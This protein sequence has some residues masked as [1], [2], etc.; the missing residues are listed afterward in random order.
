MPVQPVPVVLNIGDER[1]ELSEDNC[2]VC[3]FTE[4]PEND[5]IYVYDPSTLVIYNNRAAIDQLM[6]L[7]YPMQVRRL[8]TQWDRDAYEKYIDMLTE[9]LDH[10]LEEM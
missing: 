7:G 4:A 1:I 5:H 10:E 2:W 9:E 8:P 6:Q 3:L